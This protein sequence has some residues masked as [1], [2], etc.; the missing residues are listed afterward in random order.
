[1]HA[2]TNKLVT[3]GLPIYKRLEYL[4]HI[5]KILS[6]QDYPHI[7]LLVSDNG[8]NG[9]K[10]REIVAANYPR[11]FRFRQN[12]ST[13]VVSTHFNQ[14]IREASGE[15]FMM[16]CD[17]DEISSNYVSELVRQLEIHPQASL[18]F[19]RQENFDENGVTI[20][21]SREPLPE[22]LSG[23]DFIHAIWGRF[24]YGYDMVAT[25][26]ARTSEIRACGGY[27]DFA[28]GC[29]IENVLVTKLCLNSH[30]VFSPA[31][32]FRWRVDQSSFGWSGTVQEFASATR[33]FLQFLSEDPVIRE[34]VSTHPGKGREIRSCLSRM[35][36]EAYLWRWADIYKKALPTGQWAKAA[37]VMPFIPEYYGE[38]VRTLVHAA[39]IGIK[40]RLRSL[41]PIRCGQPE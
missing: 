34:F 35:A 14:I 4:P 9:S 12:E 39:K 25:F 22:S 17:D 8:M 3:I 11:P 5:L 41:V 36:W 18:A 33:G 32:V 23:P 40:T 19:A 6:E 28:R 2:E 7:E 20:S 24:E 1:M 37:F 38:V 29:H 13:V 10:V 15:Y 27:P 30:V 21:K 16:L 26:L 31:C